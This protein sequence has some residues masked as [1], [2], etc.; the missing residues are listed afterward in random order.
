PGRQPRRRPPGLTPPADHAVVPRA[1]P[2]LGSNRMLGGEGQSLTPSGPTT[3]P[4][5]T[6]A[7]PPGSASTASP[8]TVTPEPKA[9]SPRT[10][11]DRAARREGVPSSNRASNAAMVL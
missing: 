1:G 6:R 7:E 4:S 8:V 10:V 5:G 11:S 2:L 9:Q 3:A